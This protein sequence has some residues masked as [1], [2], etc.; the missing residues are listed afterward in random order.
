MEVLALHRGNATVGL[1]VGGNPTYLYLQRY[2][3]TEE[4]GPCV[5]PAHIAA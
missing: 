1:Q 3:Q 2:T 5:P 4:T